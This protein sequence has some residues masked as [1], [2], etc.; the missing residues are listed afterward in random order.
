MNS[1]R[2]APEET[3]TDPAGS[4]P[5]T[6][7]GEASI[8]QKEGLP[9]PANQR[10]M[11]TA[12]DGARLS[13]PY[14]SPEHETLRHVVR[15]FVE[16]EVTP[17]V[18]AWEA[19]GAIPREIFRRLGELG[20]LGLRFPEA[21]GGAAGDYFATV[22]LA[23]E[24]A[25]CGAGSLPMAVAVQTEMV[26]PP[27]L[28]FGTED[29]KQRY[30]VP[31]IRGEKIGALAITEPG[32]GSDVAGLRTTAVREGSGF[33]LSGSKSFITNGVAADFVLVVARTAPAAGHRGFSL[34][35]VDRQIPGFHVARKLDKVGMRAS[36]TAE[37]F[38]DGCLV[39][40]GALLGEEHQGF[41]HLMWELQG[42]RLISAVGAVAS[43]QLALD[44]ALRYA[45]ERVQFGRPIG[46]FQ[47]IRHRL[48]RMAAQVEAVRRFTY[49]AARQFDRGEYPVAEISMAKLAGA[50]M[51]C[52]VIDDALQIFGG[53]GYM[54]DYPIERVWRDSRLY[55][56]GGGADEIMREI[57]AKERFDQAAGR[58]TGER[59]PFSD[60]HH[61]FRRTVRAF[62]QREIVPRVEEWERAEAIPRGLFRTMADAGYLGIQLD[63]AYG[64]SEAC[65]LYDAVFHEE[66]ARCGSGSV[67]AAVGAHTGL[68]MPLLARLGTED[69]KR[70]Y[71]APSIQG[72][73]I[74]ALAITEPDAG[75]DVAG[76]STTATREA[77]GYRLM[78]TKIFITNGVAANFV[79][80]AA[81]TDS[82]VGRR[83]ISLFVVDKDTPGFSV[84]RKLEKLGWRASD[85]AE[86]AF[87]GCLVP[88]ADLLGEEHRGFF[89]LIENF[90]WER[91]LIAL[92]SVVTAEVA[93]EMALAHAR[94][95]VLFGKPLI[96]FQAIRHRLAD[97]ATDLGVA[98]GLTDHALFL[99][100][101]GDEC[102]KEVAMAKLIATETACTITDEALQF[103]G[104]YGYMMEYPIQRLWRD[105]RLGRIGGGTSEIMAEVIA[106]RL[107]LPQDR[108]DH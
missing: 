14:F 58:P 70:R 73:L 32:A 75:S 20:L 78:G 15:R 64:G 86:L 72:E 6:R 71:L 28:K 92:Q 103:H 98:R 105:A 7:A 42:E 96:E 61:T 17:H 10:H 19:E 25:R 54:A 80:V 44:L 11:R 13:P 52:R 51:A 84:S 31:A 63:E 100:T 5:A 36:D 95:R 27:I 67:A 38:F 50:R 82:R 46:A 59:W 35:L 16:T 18:D 23:E 3:Q 83:G 77:D 26:T 34:F 1:T 87:D 48:A 49:A 60:E 56:I 53:Y 29:Q 97:C 4:I 33:R 45:T 65:P 88:T 21:Y 47:A 24:L 102:A 62:V 40:A 12:L 81:K 93:L 101:Q 107:G 39:P 85:T 68:V 89:Y 55:R 57:I 41:F 108:R 22:V 37:L 79:I 74:G 2:F 94:A 104:G 66:L 69:Q 106:D 9:I 8:T 76:L 91:L 90:Q 43:A 99:F 30:L